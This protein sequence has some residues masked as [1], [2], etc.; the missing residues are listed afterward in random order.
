M[1]RTEP[2]TAETKVGALLDAW[3]ELEETLVA[4]SPRFEKLKN[5]LLRRTVAKVATLEKAAAIGGVPV[6]DV[7]RALRS[8]AGQ[9]LGEPAA[10]SAPTATPPAPAPVAAETPAWVRDGVVVHE[11]DADAMLA[12]DVHPLAHVRTHAAKLTEGQLL[13]LDVSFRPVPLLDVLT[14]AG[15]PVHVQP[16]GPLFRVFVGPRRAR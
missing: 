7:V 11:V 15:H 6:R 1:N 3:P 10:A 12:K 5:P 9:D 8:A 2:I 13:R 14:G 16:D 4:L